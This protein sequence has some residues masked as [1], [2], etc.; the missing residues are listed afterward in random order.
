MTIFDK[1]LV[2]FTQTLYFSFFFF[3]LHTGTMVEMGV[4]SPSSLFLS[5]LNFHA[6]PALFFCT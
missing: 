3:F 1:A 2:I 6:Q 4:M 5:S